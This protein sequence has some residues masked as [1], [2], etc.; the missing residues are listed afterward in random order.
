MT[1]NVGL[2]LKCTLGTARLTY[3][4]CGFRRWP[5]VIEGTWALTVSDKNV[6]NEL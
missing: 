1:L 3:V 6:A 5:C 4:C 2:N